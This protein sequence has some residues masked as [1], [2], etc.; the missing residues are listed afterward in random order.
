[1]AAPH[2][3]PPAYLDECVDLALV[4]S[5]RERG[6]TVTAAA[7]ERR[8]ALE[9]DE[10]LRYAT[11]HGLVIVTHNAR[12]FQ[13][14]HTAFERQ[15]VSH[16]GVIVV[17]ETGPLSRLTIRAAMMLD[18]ISGQEYANHL[19]KWG[20]LQTRLTQGFRLSSYTHTETRLA[21]GHE[22]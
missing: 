19:F 16:G 3:A 15:R 20:R 13:R 9:D 7:L 4:Y 1:M 10:Q 2:R 8:T 18:W 17:P 22:P 6:F 12:H 11:S 5:L 21:L 14:L